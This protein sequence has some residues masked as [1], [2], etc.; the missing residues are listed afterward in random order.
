MS[1]SEVRIPGREE[2]ISPA[3]LIGRSQLARILGVSENATRLM[4]SR[5]EIKAALVVVGRALFM[6]EDAKRWK[7]ERDARKAKKVARRV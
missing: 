2:L 4:E 7:A 5:G 6:P 1:G 3:E